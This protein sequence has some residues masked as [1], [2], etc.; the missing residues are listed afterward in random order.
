MVPHAQAYVQATFN[1]T[2]VSITDPEGNVIG[3]ASAGKAG[4]KGSRKGTPF[5]A[6]L[7]GQ[8][9]RHRGAGSRRAIGR[10]PGEGAGGRARVGDPGAAGRPESPSTRSRTSPRFHTTAAGPASGAGCSDRTESGRFPGGRSLRLLGR[11][12]SRGK[13]HRFRLPALPPGA[14]EAVSEG[15]PL[16]QGEVRDRAPRLSAGPARPAPWPEDP[17]LRAPAARE[18]EGQAHLRHAGAPVPHLLREGRP[19]EGHHR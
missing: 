12:E 5:A 13:I 17:G 3:W 11:R 15:R 4:F 7:A 9:C 2:L 18:A 8:R 10:R 6:Q 14:D 16:L 1:N 19:Q